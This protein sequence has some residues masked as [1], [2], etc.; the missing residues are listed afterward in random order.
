MEKPKLR[1]C[2]KIGSEDGQCALE[3]LLGAD[4]TFLGN[5]ISDALI[6]TFMY[7]STIPKGVRPTTE[8]C[9]RN[10]TVLQGN[11]LWLTEGLIPLH[12]LLLMPLLALVHDPATK[13]IHKE[14][15]LTADRKD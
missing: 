3:R 5:T 13:L 1:L 11:N 14:L 7:F 9:E 8:S 2:P 12:T 15:A 6:G 4:V 10:G